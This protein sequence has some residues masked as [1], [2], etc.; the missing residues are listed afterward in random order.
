MMQ[1][2][3]LLVGKIE[4]TNRVT[5]TAWYAF[6][7]AENTQIEYNQYEMKI[8][9]SHFLSSSVT[10][11]NF[12]RKWF[13]KLSVVTVR[14]AVKHSWAIW[15][16]LVFLPLAASASKNARYC[17]N[18]LRIKKFQ[19]NRSYNLKVQAIKNWIFKNTCLLL[20]S[21]Q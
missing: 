2:S 1:L 12:S 16:R 9:K 6:A 19:T 15:A 20:V 14:L 18:K 3:L 7:R 10:L 21:Q 11:R 4:S 5:G 8:P 13:S 17:T